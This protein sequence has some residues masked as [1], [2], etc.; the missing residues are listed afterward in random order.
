[1][2]SKTNTSQLKKHLKYWIFVL[3]FCYGLTTGMHYL[4]RPLWF[5]KSYEHTDL[6]TFEM[7]YTILLLPLILVR[8][9]YRVT[10]KLDKR[11]WFFISAAIICSCIYLSA[12]LHFLNWAD[13]VGS[14]D[15]PDNETLMVMAFEWQVGLIITL[16]GLTICFVRLYRKKKAVRSE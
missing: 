1:L 6:A 9:I 4:L 12:Q 11:N 14:R 2:S 5:D 10:K 3:L 8:V 7:F 16:I 15:H 13:S